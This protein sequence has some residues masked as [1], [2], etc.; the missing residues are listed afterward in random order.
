MY[1]STSSIILTGEL[2]LVVGHSQCEVSTP[3]MFLGS[4]L[5]F[6]HHEFDSCMFKVAFEKRLSILE[7]ITWQPRPLTGDATNSGR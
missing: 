6:G 4:V 2:F 5:G 1:I 7:Y 3:A